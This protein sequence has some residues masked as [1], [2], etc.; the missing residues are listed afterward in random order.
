MFP[1]IGTGNGSLVWI[2]KG[3]VVDFAMS[4]LHLT[5]EPIVWKTEA[6]FEERNYG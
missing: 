1:T 2:K 3:Q 5:P 6:A 4:A